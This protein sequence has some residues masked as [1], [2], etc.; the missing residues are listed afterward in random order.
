MDREKLSELTVEQRY[1]AGLLI[2]MGSDFIEARRAEG[3][4]LP[5]EEEANK[6]VSAM[7]VWLEP[8]F[9]EK[10]PEMVAK[11]WNDGMDKWSDSANVLMEMGK[12]NWT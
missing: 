10:A 6:I 3:Q 1:A 2:Q 4:S 11:T 12:I 8:L 5:P 9:N 7:M